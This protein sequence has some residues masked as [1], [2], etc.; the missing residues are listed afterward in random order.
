MK[1]TVA[2]VL[3][4]DKRK[5]LSSLLTELMSG[6][7]S[8]PDIAKHPTSEAIRCLRL[9]SELYD[10]VYVEDKELTDFI[11]RRCCSTEL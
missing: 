7:L 9:A 8:K 5:Q 2:D 11:R 3:S 10:F 1:E 4:D 6:I